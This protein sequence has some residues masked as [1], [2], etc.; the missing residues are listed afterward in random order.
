M[1]ISGFETNER[2]LAELGTRLKS[3]R[4]RQRLKQEDLAERSGVGKSTV[5]RLEK[6][7]S[8]QFLNLI[9]IMR[10]LNLLNSIEVLLPSAEMSPMEYLYAKAQKRPG[11]VRASAVADSGAVDA[12]KKTAGQSAFVW[13]EDK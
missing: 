10:V 9:K 7:E 11:R 2:I 5:E 1:R 4:I 6:G 12:A 13:N 8:V 3:E